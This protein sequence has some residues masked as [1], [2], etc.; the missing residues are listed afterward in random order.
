MITGLYAA[1]SGMVGLEKRHDVIANNL[2]NAATPGYKR[3]DGV[4]QGYYQHY[5]GRPVHPHLHNLR[6]GPGGG[7]RLDETYTDRSAGVI[8]STGDPLNVALMGPG[9]IAVDTPQGERYTRSGQMAINAAGQLATADGHV[10]LSADG[11]PIPV[12]GMEF[13]ISGDGEVF[14][15]G[16]PVGQLR[17]VGFEEPGLLERQG[18]T[19]YAAPEEALEGMMAPAEGVQVMHK[20]LELSNVQAPTEMANMIQGLRAYEANSRVIVTMDETTGRLID[21][22]GM[23]S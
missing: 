10:V 22:V 17:I 12:E 23:P 13:V 6:A 18:H 11:A 19:L 4:F 3:M 15:E 16:A 8:S 7:A 2:A 5:L 21:Q 1:A 9:Y 14:V 20:A